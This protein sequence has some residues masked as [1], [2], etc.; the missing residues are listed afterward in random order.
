M[1]GE[2]EARPPCDRAWPPPGTSVV[3]TRLH[4]RRTEGDASPDPGVRQVRVVIM[5]GCVIERV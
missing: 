1:P 3:I 2:P 5:P 4:R